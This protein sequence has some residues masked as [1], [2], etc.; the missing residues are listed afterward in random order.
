MPTVVIVACEP[1]EP[2]NRILK[3]Q[4]QFFEIE[5]ITPEAKMKIF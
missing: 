2:T 4:K 5:I 1:A 3:R